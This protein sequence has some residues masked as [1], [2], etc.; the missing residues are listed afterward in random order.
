MVAIVECAT[1]MREPAHD[2]PVAADHLLPVNAEVLSR[3]VRA[4]RHRQTP[5]QQ[6]ADVAGPAGL[7]WQLRQIHVITFPHLLLTDRIAHHFRLHR[8]DLPQQRQFVPGV[9]QA[10][11]RFRLLQL[12][13][14]LTEFTQ[15]RDGFTTHAQ[16]HAVR[17]AEQIAPHRHAVALGFFKQQR[18]PTLLQH[19]IT[20]LGHFQFR[21]DFDGNA[22]HLTVALQ[23][24]DEVA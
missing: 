6:G 1:A 2:Q 21:I 24:G 15:R 14:H 13:Q 7:D 9:L 4:A 19:P 12:R 17:R 23:P 8:H 3:L 22:F 10:F 11:R 5:G 18:G 20:N 16:R